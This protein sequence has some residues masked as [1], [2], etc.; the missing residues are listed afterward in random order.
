MKGGK[1]SEQVQ[2]QVAECTAMTFEPEGVNA[3]VHEDDAGEDE[4][5]LGIPSGGSCCS[6]LVDGWPSLVVVDGSS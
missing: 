6:N 4:R 5:H 3:G 2:E 1:A